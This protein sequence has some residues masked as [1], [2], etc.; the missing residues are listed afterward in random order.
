MGNSGY[1][2]YA[3]PTFYPTGNA[4]IHSE[5]DRYT[6]P[7]ECFSHLLKYK[8]GRFARHPRWRY[9]ALNSQTRLRAL[10]EGK[11]YVKQGLNSEQYIVEEVQAV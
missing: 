7:A 1:I 8:D 3:F 11:I 9:F 6:K 10:Q 4:G 5:H 2:A